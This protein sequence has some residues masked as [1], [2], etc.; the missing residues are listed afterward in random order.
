LY[1]LIQ[2]SHCFLYFLLF[3]HHRNVEQDVKDVSISH[4]WHE[5]VLTDL[6][7][8]HPC[9]DRRCMLWDVCETCNS[10]DTDVD[11]YI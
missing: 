10:W 7:G 8:L 6:S 4:S 1:D 5:I 3:Q 11:I 9:K 2:I